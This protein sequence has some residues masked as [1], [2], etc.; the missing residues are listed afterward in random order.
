MVALHAVKCLAGLDV[1]RP[2]TIR[3]LFGANEETSMADVAWYLENYES[4]AFLFTPD[5][6][7]PCAT[8]RRAATTGASRARPSPTR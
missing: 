3:F 8:A 2:Y 7:F 4:P 5:A 6:D 1:A